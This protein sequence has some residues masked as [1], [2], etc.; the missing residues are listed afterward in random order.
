[1][2]YKKISLHVV[3]WVLL[4]VMP[5]FLL[6]VFERISNYAPFHYYLSCLLLVPFFYCSNHLILTKRALRYIVFVLFSFFVF[7]YFP[8]LV[9]KLLPENNFTQDLYSIRP[10]SRAKVR[11]GTIILFLLVLAVSIAK[12]MYNLKEVGRKLKAE[13]VKAELSLLKSQINP[14][15]LFNSLNTIYYLTLQKADNAPQAVI[16]LSDMMRYVLTEAKEELVP[17]DHERQYVDKFIALQKM[18]IPKKTKVNYS[19]VVEDVNV[20]VAPLLLMPFIENAFKY[21]ISANSDTV[22]QI[23]IGYKQGKLN[24]FSENKMINTDDEDSGTGVGICNVKKR[25]GLLYPDKHELKIQEEGSTFT[26]QL[27]ILL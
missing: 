21:G 8:I 26:V 19:F 4:I 6:D 22:I 2:T 13:N 7:L 9:C 18:R 24:F 20:Q 5:V 25:L 11:M 14:H 23:Q 17:I 3:F 10:S 27:S 15:F 12:H 1:M 16:T